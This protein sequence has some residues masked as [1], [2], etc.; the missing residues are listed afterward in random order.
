SKLMVERILADC[1]AAHGLQ[2]TALRYFN[3]S[4][5]DP[6]GETGEAHDPEPHLIPRALM[7]AEGT[8]RDF[9]VFG[10]DYPTPDGTCIRDYIHVSDLADAHV[11]ALRYLADGGD[12]LPISLGVGRGFSVREILDSVERVTG[13]KVPATYGPRRPGDPAMLIADPSRARTLL[14]FRPRFTEIDQIVETAWA[15]HSRHAERRRA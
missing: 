8:L 5:G 11:A 7:A 14:D 15:W 4:G 1:G 10:T 3:A 9:Q 2:W 13:R 12:S 6:D